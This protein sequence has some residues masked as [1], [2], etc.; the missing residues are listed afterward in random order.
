MA[1]AVAN[2]PQSITDWYHSCTATFEKITTGFGYLG[3]GQDSGGD[4]T[5]EIALRLVQDQVG[6]FRVWS[7]NMG[8]HYPAHSRMSLDFKLKE[9]SYLQNTVVELLEEL[10][11]SLEERTIEEVEETDGDDGEKEKNTEDDN[12]SSTGSEATESSSDSPLSDIVFML[13]DIANIISC[14]YTLSVAIPQPVL[15]DRL[16]ISHRD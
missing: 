1:M 9:A 11:T 15:Q 16:Q 3:P 13:D 2:P 10:N 14:L 6:R 8:A 7:G 12:V 4:E 5:N